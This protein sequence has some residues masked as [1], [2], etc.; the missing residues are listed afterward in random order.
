[1]D[2][3][4]GVEIPEARFYWS[5]ADSYYW[6]RKAKKGYK[7]RS[8]EVLQSD[9]EF[10]EL[11]ENQTSNLPVEIIRPYPDAPPYLLPSPESEGFTK[12]EPLKDEPGLFFEFATVEPTEEGILEF[13]NR[14]GPLANSYDYPK[15]RKGQFWVYYGD[16]LEFWISEL[17]CMA[18]VVGLWIA[19]E[20]NDTAALARVIEWSEDDN[21]FKTVTVKTDTYS[22]LLIHEK[23]TPA[24]FQRLT[25][26]DLRL[27]ARWFIVWWVNIKLRDDSVDLSLGIEDSNL[28]FVSFLLPKSL[29]SVMWLQ[30]HNA[31]IGRNKFK[32][33]PICHEWED[34]TNKSSRWTKHP[35]CA[36][37][38]RAREHY[39]RTKK[40]NNQATKKPARKPV[41]KAPAKKKPA[42]KSTTS[43][44]GK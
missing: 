22:L 1:M 23:R 25:P 36:N 39:E 28:E 37:R 26:G 43:K 30:F 5:K 6:E 34:V 10:R 27:P 38:Q 32:Q 31:V 9:K 24:I 2:I 7:P 12:W 13:A 19:L 16:S 33:C 18:T 15:R 35:K 8:P 42:K 11:I 4:T 44:G 20:K 17:D 41:K 21:G 14:Y 29:L 3:E 40:G